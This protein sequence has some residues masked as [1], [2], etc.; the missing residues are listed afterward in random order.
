MHLSEGR[1][2]GVA[3]SPLYALQALRSHAG[4]CAQVRESNIRRNTDFVAFRRNPGTC[5]QPGIGHGG[6]ALATHRCHARST[7]PA[8]CGDELRAGDIE[9]QRAVQTP[10]VTEGKGTHSSVLA[11][12]RLLEISL[13]R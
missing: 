1:E 12:P 7:T 5:L 11:S 6:T 13:Y 10:R 8:Q 3:A 2:R 9:I 4:L